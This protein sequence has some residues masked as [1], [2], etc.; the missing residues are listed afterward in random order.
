MASLLPIIHYAVQRKRKREQA[1]ADGILDDC[2]ASLR[3]RIAA[4]ITEQLLRR[5]LRERH[6]LTRPSLNKPE[7][8]AWLCIEA[9]GNDMAYLEVTSLTVRAF[10]ILHDEFGPC[11]QGHWD[12]LRS[13]SSVKGRKRSMTTW[14]VLGITL[15]WF[16][17]PYEIT[18]LA[19]IFGQ[20]PAC[21]S[22][23]VRD[24]KNA[25]LTILPRMRL[26][27]I[28]WPSPRQMARHA[29]RVQLAQPSLP[30]C[31]GFVDGL[32]IAIQDPSDP[33]EQ[34][35]YYNGEGMRTGNMLSICQC[36]HMLCTV[37]T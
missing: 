4:A 26:A 32:N 16:H 29:A 21:V 31:F 6:Y 33:E 17:Q 36:E 23:Y 10:T 1:Y 13:K 25:L 19:L 11:L 3:V 12:S 15:A 14:S 22:S 9:S 24:G 18:D 34:T 2:I 28:T 35:A 8:S 27:R 7:E 20:V 30:G 37:L 5:A